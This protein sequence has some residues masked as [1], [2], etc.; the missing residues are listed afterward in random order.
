M[1]VDEERGLVFCPIGSST[2]DFWGGDR[3]GND[4]YADCLLVLDAATGKHVWHFQF[5]HHDLWDRDPPAP[6]T[7]S[8]P[9]GAAARDIPAVAE[10]T[11]SGHVWVFNRETGEHRFPYEEIAVPSSDLA[12]EVASPHPAAAAEARALRPPALHGR[13]HH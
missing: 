10:V 11:K 13:P 7:R 9:C 4:L 2:F 5:T 1:T 6:P 12:G 8:S 3:V